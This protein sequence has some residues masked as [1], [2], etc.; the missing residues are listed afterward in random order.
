MEGGV[1]GQDARASGIVLIGMMGAGKSSVG[2]CLQKQTGRALFDVDEMIAA[3]F[4]SSISKIFEMHGED[5]FR[6]AETEI[7]RK[8]LSECGG[9]ASHRVDATLSSR[10]S[11]DLVSKE[12]GQADVA[13]VASTSLGRG[14]PRHAIVVTGGGI[15]LRGANV[16]LL[17]QLGMVVWLDADAQI[18]FER[19]S[20]EGNRPLLVTENPRETFSQLLNARRPIYAKIAD[21]KIDTSKLTSEETADA[22]LD[23]I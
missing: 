8:L 3:R 22:I 20:R 21:V 6:D 14:H 9:D 12:S 1:H 23:K 4:G 10:E 5:K 19:A 18:L 13:S 17:K 16:G 2:R 15:I 11:G 7:L